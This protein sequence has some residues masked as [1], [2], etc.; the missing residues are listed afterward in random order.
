VL[1]EITAPGNY[2][3]TASIT[4]STL[5]TCISINASDVVLDGQG[6]IIDGQDT[7]PSNGIFIENRTAT[8]GNITIKN[9]IMTDWRYGIRLNNTL[10]ITITN[11]TATSNYYSIYATNTVDT[12]ITW[13]NLSWNTGRGIELYNVTRSNITG[14]NISYIN[15]TSVGRGIYISNSTNNTIN[16]NN[17]SLNYVQGIMVY[18]STYTSLDNNFASSNK[19]YGIYLAGS[20]YST[21]TNNTATNNT[22][23]GLIVSV[24]NYANISNNIFSNNNNNINNY[25]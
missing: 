8:I 22:Y 15:G 21:V 17:A 9:V 14:N 1:Q 2:V 5:R 20:N 4:D 25:C 24:T 16:R 18:Y 13:N 19:D 10:N 3:L 6:F 12:I 23:S 11:C 7:N